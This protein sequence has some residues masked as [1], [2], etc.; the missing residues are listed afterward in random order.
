MKLILV[1][2]GVI[3]AAS[4]LFGQTQIGNST[5]ENWEST[6]NELHEPVNWNSFK[7]ASG[8]WSSFGGQQ[9]DWSTDIRPGSTGTKSVRIWSNS[10]LGIIANGNVTLGQINMGSTTANDPSNYNYTKTSDAN[11]SE[12]L[13]D[14]PDSIVFWVK[15]VPINGA[16]QARA[17]II[18]HDNYNFKDP[19]EVG[20]INTVATAILNYGATG[21]NWVRKSIPFNYVSATANTH[22]L[23]TFTSNMTPG[24][25]SNNDQVWIDDIELIYNPVSTNLPVV[26]VN[27][28][29]TTFENV[30]IAIDV[31][32]ND[33]DPEDDFNIAGITIITAPTNGSVA[34]NTSTGVITYTPNAGYFGT[35]SFEYEV[36]DNGTP[37]FCDIA[38]VN[39]NILEVIVG[40]NPIVAINDNVTIGMDSQIV[41]PVTANDIDYENDIN[42]NSLVVSSSASN[43]STVVNTITGEV[44][45]TPNG[46]F[47]GF[48]S[49]TY[50]ICDGGSPFTCDQAVV[51]I[52]VT[53]T[54]GFIEST[55]ENVSVSVFN[56]ELFI[57]S[58]SQLEGIYIIYS[59]VGTI[60]QEG[61]ISSKVDFN[62]P[63]GIYFVHLLSDKG[64]L[65]RKII[66]F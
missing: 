46:G 32:A 41:I 24:G 49:F 45:Y 37:V 59:S 28:G 8:S 58:V 16:S 56:R 60:V 61:V 39:I 44:T 3:S 13:T 19:N 55:L 11:F 57:Q 30:A 42:L 47:V 14:T 40:N 27:D 26:A 25:G 51:F 7:T 21:G 52:N 20:G 65:I 15:Y 9:M 2:I 43:G 5:F 66:S 4:V 23:I 48:D 54:N 29:V 31:L 10:V 6:S 53:S 38:T 22:I 12:S 36:C 63:T 35:D 17:S 33:T 62:Q 64:D 34:I 1:F 18:L 50:T